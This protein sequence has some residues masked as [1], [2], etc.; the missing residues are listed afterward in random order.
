MHAPAPRL[1]TDSGGMR[2]RAARDPTGGMHDATTTR[3][4]YPAAALARREADGG[5]EV[6]TCRGTG[7]G[8]VQAQNTEEPV[9]T[10]LG[11]PAASLSAFYRACTVD[12][13]PAR[14]PIF[15]AATRPIS[16][17]HETTG[18]RLIDYKLRLPP[19]PETGFHTES[20]QLYQLCA[21]PHSGNS[22]GEAR[23]AF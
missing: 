12:T 16:L 6:G 8:L 10:K 3:K 9:P 14:L 2:E 4:Y 22:V 20:L 13:T 18:K 17:F 23:S 7:F 11:L 1:E 5:R 15:L 21:T 19:Q